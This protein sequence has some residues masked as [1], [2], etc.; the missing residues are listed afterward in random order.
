MDA[1]QFFIQRFCSAHGCL[2]CFLGALGLFANPVNNA[3]LSG[4]SF[5]VVIQ[6][7]SKVV[8]AQLAGMPFV[9][10]EFHGRFSTFE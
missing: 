6:I 7:C 5:G 8:R 2:S 1:F 9:H 10:K 3:A 4:L